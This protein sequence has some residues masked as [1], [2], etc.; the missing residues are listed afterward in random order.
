MIFFDNKIE[1]L[2]YLAFFDTVKDR[3]EAPFFTT[4]KVRG[5]CDYCN[6][7]TEMA[8]YI[9]LEN[10]D[11]WINKRD[12]FLCENCG[13]SARLRSFYQAVNQWAPGKKDLLI[14][15]KATPFFRLLT[16]RYNFLGTEYFGDH[17]FGTEVA[18]RGLQ[19]RNENMMD[20]TFADQSYDLIAH[21][22]VLEHIPDPEL[23]LQDNF[24]IL[25]EGGV[26]IFT[27]PFYHYIPKTVV[28]A[29]VENNEV[30]HL[31]TPPVYHGDPLSAEGAL[32]FQIFGQTFLDVLF[33]VGFKKVMVGFDFD[34]SRCIFSCGNPYPV[35]QMH[36][37]IFFAIK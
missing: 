4:P 35:G 22:E 17:E 10:K 14:F 27:T 26:L 30:V 15:E 8:N 23:A 9:P 11:E 19:I 24:R 12:Q 5:K 2:E 7:V 29:K 21:Q 1:L 6:A 34:V 32:V 20:T 13:L 16:K 28:N 36:P 3:V 33:S 25:R 37:V 31:V 18:F